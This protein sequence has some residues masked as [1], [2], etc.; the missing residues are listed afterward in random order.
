VLAASPQGLAAG[1][2]S[3]RATVDGP[4]AFPGTREVEARLILRTGASDERFAV[5]VR[6]PQYQGRNPEGSVLLVD[7]S[8]DAVSLDGPGTL[9]Q[10]ELATGVPGCS[11]RLNRFH[12]YEPHIPTVDVDVPANSSTTVVVRFAT[13][14]FAPW[15][16]TQYRVAFDLLD[17][18][19]DGSAS[20]LIA[21]RTVRAGL[22]TLT[23]RRGIR[24]S[25]RTRPPTFS[26]GT[27]NPAVIRSG[28]LLRVSG[29]TTPPAPRARIRLRLL[30]PGRRSTFHTWARTQ[31]DPR[32]RF[33]VRR[34]APKQRG[35]YELWTFITPDDRHLV[36]DYACPTAF[37]IR[38]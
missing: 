7:N 28:R 38:R 18:R 17:E 10:Q 29:A 23:G 5:R 34:R 4:I 9:G 13:G 3:A 22:P 11:P 14:S 37:E 35:R 1:A 8:P 16:A 32:G 2:L 26:S 6:A 25:V 21:P 20:T 31:T 27:Q 12:G 30:G 33:T 19:V 36:A 15:T 24:V